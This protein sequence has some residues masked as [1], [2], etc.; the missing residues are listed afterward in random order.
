MKKRIVGIAAALMITEAAMLGGTCAA[1]I[2]QDNIDVDMPISAVNL[3]RINTIDDGY[4]TVVQFEHMVYARERT[5]DTKI[6]E[7]DYKGYGHTVN[8]ISVGSK[9]DA[10]KVQNAKLVANWRHGAFVYY[11]YVLPD[12]SLVRFNTIADLETV[13]SITRISKTL[14]DMIE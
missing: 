6:L 9:F 11:T 8:G 1:S 2:T 4:M 14:N 7:V 5:G 3:N 13:E 12:N 10:D